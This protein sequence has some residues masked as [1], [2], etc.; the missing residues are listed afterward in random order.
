[1][2]NKQNSAHKMKFSVKD[3]CSKCEQTRSLLRICS[4]LL[5]NP[6]KKLHF[7][8]NEIKGKQLKENIGKKETKIK[9]GTTCLLCK[10]YL[11]RRLPFQ[12]V[13]T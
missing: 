9:E 6:Y 7:L 5:K 10:G 4:H 13:K 2:C 12:G 3:F 11:P 8:S 1:M